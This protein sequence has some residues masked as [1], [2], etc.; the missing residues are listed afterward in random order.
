MQVHVWIA[1]ASRAAWSLLLDHHSA[2]QALGTE[3]AKREILHRS[4]IMNLMQ[5]TE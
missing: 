4:R 5:D 1:D 3:L 2:L